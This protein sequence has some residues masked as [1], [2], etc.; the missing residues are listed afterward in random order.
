MFCMTLYYTMS[1]IPRNAFR[2]KYG[3]PG[4]KRLWRLKGWPTL[5][6]TPRLLREDII[7]AVGHSVS[8][9]AN[10]LGISRQHLHAIMAEKKPVTPKVAVLLGRLFEDGLKIWVRMQG[11]YDTWHAQYEVDVS[12]IRPL[13]K[14]A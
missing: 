7:P 4:I 14:V 2:A 8:E 9:I 12:H 6:L 1:D 5:R 3:I 13:K 10:L 11:A